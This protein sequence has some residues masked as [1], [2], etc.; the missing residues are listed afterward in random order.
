[1]KHQDKHVPTI[2]CFVGAPGVGKTSIG[3]SI[4]ESLGRSFVKVSLGGVRDEAEIRGHRRTY[5][6]AMPGRIINGM[7]QAKSMN[8]VFMLDEIDKIGQDLRGD[9][10]AALLEVLDPEQN[11]VYEDHYVDM[12]FDLSQIVFIAT[13]NTLDTIPSAL[14]DRLEVI[15]YAGYTQEEKFHITKD[16][17]LAKVRKANGL[18]P[19]QISVSDSLLKTII[20]RYTKEA[21]VRNV[22]RELNKIMR[23][24][25]RTITQDGTKSVA[26]TPALIKKYLG[27]E[28]YDT[29]LAGQA[30]EVGVATGLA[31]TSVGGDALFVEVALTAGKGELKLTGQL[32]D[33]MKESAQA[34]MTYVRSHAAKLNI[35][36][37]RIDST[38]VHIHVPEGAVPK[39]GPSAGITI[40]TAIIS[41]YTQRPV[42]KHIAMTGEVTLR[43][44]VMRI[45]GLKEK[46]IAAHQAGITTILIP[47]ENE[48]DLVEVPDSV[49]HDITFIPVT[50]MDEVIQ[51][52]LSRT[53]LS[54]SKIKKK[55][56][57]R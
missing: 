28:K 14:L 17:L 40:C 18:E 56:A 50:R 15:R 24:V 12:P 25:A 41:A 33:V 44:R 54:S 4:A 3:K 32:G 52:A 1:M 35:T 34:A 19:K 23:K 39:D 20:E 2:L 55:V 42:L 11:K 27:P 8:P 16:H 31:W 46:S 29:T 51:Q 6:G 47:K 26:I 38:N 13:A 30:D 21:G 45:G 36:Q 5:V 53:A 22:E 9:P 7:K 43:G 37:K 10:S 48:R 49:K 57:S